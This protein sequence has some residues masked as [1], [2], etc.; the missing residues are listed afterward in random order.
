M[1]YKVSTL[2]RYRSN[3]EKLIK[4]EFVRMVSLSLLSAIGTKEESQD[5]KVVENVQMAS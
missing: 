3:L 4:L 1:V 5:V 2:G